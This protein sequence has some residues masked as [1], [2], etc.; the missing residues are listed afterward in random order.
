[1]TPPMTRTSLHLTDVRMERASARQW[2]VPETAW[3][4]VTRETLASPGLVEML[5]DVS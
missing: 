2:W 4:L 1:M 5:E 3:R